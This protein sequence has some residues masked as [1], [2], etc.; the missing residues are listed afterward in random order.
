MQRIGA[1]SHR[2]CKRAFYLFL[3]SFWVSFYKILELWEIGSEQ[4]ASRCL[5]LAHGLKIIEMRRPEFALNHA[6]NNDDASLRGSDGR[7]HPQGA[8]SLP[9]AD[10]CSRFFPI[11]HP[12]RHRSLIARSHGPQAHTPLT[13]TQVLH[14]KSNQRLQNSSK[15]SRVHRKLSQRPQ[16]SQPARLKLVLRVMPTSGMHPRVSG[17]VYH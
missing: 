2:S 5:L 10:S 1:R 13:H 6:S 17:I 11:L 9:K 12:H 15:R 3:V 8:H 4:N 16:R 7:A 14:Q